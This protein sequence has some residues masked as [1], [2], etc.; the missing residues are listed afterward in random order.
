MVVGVAKAGCSKRTT[1]AD[2]NSRASESG[3]ST[4]LK[5]ASGRETVEA[6]ENV[7]HADVGEHDVVADRI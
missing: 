5:D 4:R 3:Q 1:L 2:R 6:H 7:K